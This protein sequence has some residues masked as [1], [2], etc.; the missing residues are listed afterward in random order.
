MG[1]LSCR[2]L[3][4]FFEDNTNC[5]YGIK[6]G[7]L[8]HFNYERIV[9]TDAHSKPPKNSTS[10]SKVVPYR[11]GTPIVPDRST[12]WHGTTRAGTRTTGNNEWGQ[13]YVQCS[14]L[15][16]VFR[17]WLLSVNFM[18]KFYDFH[19]KN[20]LTHKCQKWVPRIGPNIFEMK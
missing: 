16:S 9:S 12:N 8:Y 7:I 5:N 20:Q 18:A 13:T 1:K 10:S 19:Q 2:N 3:E 6:S 11:I 17:D 14:T 4:K 15:N